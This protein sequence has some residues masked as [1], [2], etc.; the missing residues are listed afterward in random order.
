[1]GDRV[2]LVAA[3]GDWREQVKEKKLRKKLRKRVT[4]L[5][6]FAA[7]NNIEHVSMFADLKDGKPFIYA[8]ASVDGVQLV[9]PILDFVEWGDA[10][11]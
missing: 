4:K 1:M 9:D 8:C 6:R 10:D 3:Q 5:L 11:A 7:E 2:R